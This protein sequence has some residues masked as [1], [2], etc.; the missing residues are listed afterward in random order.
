M[1]AYKFSEGDGEI[2]LCKVD[3]T[4]DLLKSEMVTLTS[5]LIRNTWNLRT[6]IGTTVF[7]RTSIHM[8][9]FS[10]SMP[11]YVYHGI[12]CMLLPHVHCTV[13]KSG[14][15]SIKI[16]YLACCSSKIISSTKVDHWSLLFI[17]KSSSIRGKGQSC[18][19]TKICLWS[20][21]GKRSCL[22]QQ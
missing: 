6:S 3:H 2:Q 10:V 17:W 1:P 5:I 18:T 22:L 19:C 21:Q 15:G 7:G 4:H 8:T 9:S 16:K 13:L 12:I 20:Y 14:C 11:Y